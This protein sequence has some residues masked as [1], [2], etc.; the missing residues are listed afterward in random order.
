MALFE[1]FHRGE[2][3]LHSLNFGTIILLPKG[4]EANMIE[5]YRPICL[6]NVV[7]KF[8]TKVASNRIAL[9]AQK[10][11]R[12][13]QT[14]FLP[15]RN[16]MEGAIIL[17]ETI[18][19]MHRKKLNGVLFKI[20]F[21]KAYDKVKWSFLQQTLRM[22]GFSE[23]WCNWIKT[24]VQGGNVGIKINDQLGP[25]FQTRKGLRQG[26]PLSPVLFNL[27]VDMLS[28]LIARAKVNVQVSGVVPHLV[29]DGLSILQ[30][31]DDTIIFMDH[32][33]EQATNMKLI[34]CMFEQLSGLKINF[35][36]SEFFCFSKAKEEENLYTQLFGCE[37]G[38]YPCRYLGLP[39]HYKKLNNKD[40]KNI[41]ERLRKKLSCW[42]RKMLSVGGRLVLI[43]SIMSSLPV[44]MLSFFEIPKGV[45][46][47]LEYFRS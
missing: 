45:L 21:E 15:G 3:P 32:D 41:D 39:M 43:N 38:S 42:K 47:K 10:I 23:T 40:W 9:V 26:D 13:S 16:I 12:P 46:K 44:F 37:L 6:L 27:V 14:A 1:D 24:F 25:F 4:S 8:F 31:A 18:H 20:D 17:H 33:I 11:I 5:Q 7:F 35:H 28:I 36:K 34:L 30:Y 22:K 19:E 2:L 29:E